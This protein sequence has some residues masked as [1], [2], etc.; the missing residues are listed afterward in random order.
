MFWSHKDDP[1][2]ETEIQ[3]QVLKTLTMIANGFFDN[4]DK[5]HY[6]K[7]YFLLFLVHDLQA[8]HNFI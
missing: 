2:V 5:C 1:K 6:L 3:G 7:V 4:V 8:E